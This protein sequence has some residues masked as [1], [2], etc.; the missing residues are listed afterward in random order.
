MQIRCEP[1]VTSEEQARF[2]VNAWL[3]ADVLEEALNRHTCGLEKAFLYQG[4]EY[5]FKSDELII[6]GV[7]SG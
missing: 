6:A 7:K 4:R 1:T 3:E 2:S 5:L